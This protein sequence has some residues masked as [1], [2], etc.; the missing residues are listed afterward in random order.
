MTRLGYLLAGL[1]A[2]WLAACAAGNTATP[3]PTRRAGG[4]RALATATRFRPTATATVTRTPEPT[5]TPSPSPVPSPTP[6]PD[7]YAWLTIEAL[8]Q[9]AYGGGRIEVLEVLARTSRFTRY[10]IRYP[11]DGL[12]IYGFLNV[13]PGPGPFPVVLVLH[14]YVD[15][16]KYQVLDYTTR[17]ADAIT[18]MGYV[19]LHPNY[20]NYPP[21]DI[22]P[23]LFRVGYAIDV[24]NL[25]ALVREQAGHPGPLATADGSRI[26]L[27]GHSMGGGIALRVIT[28]DPQVRAAVLYASMSGDERRNFEMIWQWSMGRAGSEELAVP[29]A[30]VD[31]ISPIH[32]LAYIQA[33]VSIHHGEA[34]SLVPV[35]WSWELCLRLRELGKPVECYFYP[36]ADHLFTGRDDRL[37]MERV[38]VFFA[39]WLGK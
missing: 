37:L 21:S 3:V 19:V 1:V 10:L 18:R 26:G 23:N 29:Q 31:R 16:L 36:N 11:S 27:F 39:K 38:Q 28:V 35:E 6:S 33:A 14:G 25:L 32:Y 4:I 30:V 15:P 12:T 7:P 17:Y 9:R 24:L 13:P 20:R 22:G 2:L 34:D 5:V 8:R